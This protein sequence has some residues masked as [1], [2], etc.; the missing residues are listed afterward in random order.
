M[1]RA[2]IAGVLGVGGLAVLAPPALATF[3]L[4]M[5]N[6]VM[7]ASSSGDSKVQFVE[8]L[9]HGGTEEVFTP[10]FAPYKLVVYDAAGNKL[11]EHTLDPTGL[12]NAAFMDTEYLISTSAADAALGVMADERLDFSLP[13]NAGQV[14]FEGNPTPPDFSCM[15]YGSISKPVPTNSQGTGS[16]HGPVP[17]DGESDQ[18]QTD[19]S[20]QAAPP[21]PKARN[22]VGT[23]M[24]SGGGGGG[25]SMS[26]P[27]TPFTASPPPRPTFAGAGFGST[28]ARLGRRGRVGVVLNCSSGSTG[29]CMGTLTLVSRHGRHTLGR[30]SFILLPGARRVIEVKLSAKALRRL[31][32]LGRLVVIATVT[33]RDAA[34]RTETS[35]TRLTLVTG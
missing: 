1:R 19:N 9:D 17:P 35:T 3:H 31:R 11:G 34:G 20:V 27:G 30:S 26:I 14:C 15:T 28:R 13:L 32:R 5:V 10:I 8:L 18:R 22:R 25:G 23:G 7:L 33:I 12:R 6:E 16:V 29:S 21:T 24:T 4:E 2:V